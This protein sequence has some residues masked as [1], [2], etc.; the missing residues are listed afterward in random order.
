M[1]GIELSRLYFEEAKKSLFETFPD[2]E[3][4]IAAGLSGEGS[5]CFG[6]DDDLSRDH[7]YEPS[8]CLWVS[9]SD[10]EKIGFKLERFYAKLPKEFMGIKRLPS[11]PDN[12]R[13][14]IITEEFF[15]RFTGF[16]HGPETARDWLGIPSYFLAE[17][18]NGEIFYDKGG[19]FSAIREKLA[20]GYPDDVRLKKLS[21]HL[22]AMGQSGQY[23][24]ARCKSRGETGAAQLAVMEFVKHALEAAHLINN[25]YCPFYKWAYRSLRNLPVLSELEPILEYLTETP[26][27]DDTAS[28]KNE[29]I[30]NIAY[31]F[32]AELKEKNLTDA[33]C[34]NLDTHAIS[35][36]YRISDGEIRNMNLMTGV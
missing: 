27:D 32:I 7:D 33:T 21:A 13:G 20:A 14:V 9:Q 29:M 3:D 23:N 35:V 34:N 16:P 2:Y 26:N 22:A 8:F 30:D 6:Y 1:K 36:N 12:R 10:Y 19:R 31:L 18:T 25:R 24:Y 4:R 5:E 15:T 17:A 11:P 28:E